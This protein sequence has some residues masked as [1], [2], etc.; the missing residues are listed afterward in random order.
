V[1]GAVLYIRVST[2][3]QEA[4]TYNLPTQTRKVEDRCERDGLPVLKTFTDAESARTTDRPQF[5]A[6]L[7]YCRAHRGKVTHVVFC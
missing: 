1:P 7:Q 4:Q 6:M 5:Q 2:A 3:A